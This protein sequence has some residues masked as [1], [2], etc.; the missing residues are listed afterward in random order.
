MTSRVSSNTGLP[1]GLKSR[2]SV[3]ALW[4][5]GAVPARSIDPERSTTIMRVMG[6]GAAIAEKSAS[7]ARQNGKHLQRAMAGAYHGILDQYKTRIG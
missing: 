1:P 5:A 3:S 6:A 2:N 4:R 7:G